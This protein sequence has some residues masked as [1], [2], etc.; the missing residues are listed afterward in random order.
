MG[1]SDTEERTPTPRPRIGLTTYWQ[2][3]RWGV[4]EDT[5]AIVPGNYVRRV[6]EAGGVP[7]LLPPVG[8]DP[9]V[10]EVLDGL[11][12]IG[13][14]D[15]DPAR[16]GHP[17]HSTTVAQPDRDEHDARLTLAALERGLPLFAICRGL[18]VLN[19]ACGGTLHQHLPDLVPEAGPQYQPAPGQYGAVQFTVQ[20]GSLAAGLLGETAS[21]PCYHHQSLDRLAPGL[22]VTGRAADGTVEIVEMPEAPGWVLGVQFH[23]E[24][25]PHDI[26]LF[27]GFIE[28]ARQEVAA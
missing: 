19:V 25:N 28:A 2:Q 20:P 9:A 16:Y 6:V 22:Q 26:R 3:G 14:T 27:E 24:E 15:V 18:Q 11:V 4:W 23:P 21:S 5:A 17:T 1:S 13:G 10:L 7:M 8:T 12:V